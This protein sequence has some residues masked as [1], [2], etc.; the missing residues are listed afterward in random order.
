MRPPPLRRCGRRRAPEGSRMRKLTRVLQ[1][2]PALALLS[3]VILTTA[4]GSSAAAAQHQVILGAVGNSQVETVAREQETGRFIGGVRVFKRWD[5]PLINADQ[6]W[7][8]QTGHTLFL[9]VKTRLRDG[10]LMSWRD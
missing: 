2:G 5:Q 7:D 10:T 4:A 8:V 6:R 3:T 9:S 1:T